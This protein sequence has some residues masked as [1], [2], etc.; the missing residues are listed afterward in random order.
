[1][2][3]EIAYIAATLTGAAVVLTGLLAWWLHS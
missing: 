3:R 2:P 1:M